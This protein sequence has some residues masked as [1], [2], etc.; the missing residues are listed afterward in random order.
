MPRVGAGAVPG[1][2]QLPCSW[3]RQW[4]GPWLAGL[5]LKDL[6]G[7]PL[8]SLVLTMPLDKYKP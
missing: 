4:G 7:F 5:A 1:A 6:M 3:L 2:F 8:G